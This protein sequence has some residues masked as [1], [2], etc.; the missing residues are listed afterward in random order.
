MKL[1]KLLLRPALLLITLVVASFI[2]AAIFYFSFKKSPSDNLILP[3][4][5]ST[6]N[7]PA[8]NTLVASNQEKITY[9]L[10]VRLKIPKIKVD[11]AFEYVGV[12]A[13]GAM[14]VPKS[15]D[16]VGW[17]ESGA[18]PGEIG[19]A[20][21]AG[22]YGRHNGESSVFDNLYKLRA[23]DKIYVEDDQGI[24][25]SFIVRGN[26]RYDAQ[27]DASGIFISKDD[28]A[29]LNLITC[30]GNWN[31]DAQSYPTRLVIFADRE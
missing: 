23:G 24:T 22:H 1:A 13:E 9:R 21:L 16:N 17:F 20:V 11:A 30:E 6:I 25:T 18:R 31:K 7:T 8:I 26:R 2:L 12:T 27:A 29:H 19:S 28:Q 10:P 3:I 5:T 14:D 15:A 4:K